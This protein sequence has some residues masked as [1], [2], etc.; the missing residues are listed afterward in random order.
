[1][2][3]ERGFKFQPF[4]VLIVGSGGLFLIYKFYSQLFTPVLFK[5]VNLLVLPVP[6]LIA[7]VILPMMLKMLT[8]RSAIELTDDAFIN[9]FTGRAVPWDNIAEIHLKKGGVRSS[10]SLVI[11]LKQPELYFN[12]FL[13]RFLYKIKQ[14]FTA[15]D[16][17]IPTDLISGDAE[18]ILLAINAFRSKLE[19]E[20]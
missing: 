1:M 12:N 10:G 7:W 14:A 3:I 9:N 17:A 15:N 19:G 11:N 18:G 4:W 8:G 16:I 20:I 6:V 2:E 13:R 5:P